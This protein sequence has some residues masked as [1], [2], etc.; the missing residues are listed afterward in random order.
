M[1]FNFA[2]D[3]QDEI[4]KRMSADKKVALGANLWKLARELNKDK[5]IFYGGNRSKRFVSRDIRNS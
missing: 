1:S 4:F 2:Q 5:T 3:K